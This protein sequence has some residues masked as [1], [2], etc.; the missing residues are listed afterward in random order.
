MECRHLVWSSEE[1]TEYVEVSLGRYR[2]G[3]DVSTGSPRGF[4]RL[5]ST[6]H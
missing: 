5:D 2:L 3:G 6:P 4:L 1:F